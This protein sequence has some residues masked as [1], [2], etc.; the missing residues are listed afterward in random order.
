MA[1]IVRQYHYFSIPENQVHLAVTIK[2]H[3]VISNSLPRGVIYYGN[4]GYGRNYIEKTATFLYTYK[5]SGNTATET[6]AWANPPAGDYA[7]IILTYADMGVSEYTINV[8]TILD[9]VYIEHDPS[10]NPDF[11]DVYEDGQLLNDDEYEFQDRHLILKTSGKWIHCQTYTYNDQLLHNIAKYLSDK[12]NPSDISILVVERRAHD[13]EVLSCDRLRQLGYNVTIDESVNY[14]WQTEGYDIVMADT[15]WWGVAKGSLLSDVYDARRSVWSTGDNSGGY[16]DLGDIQE[17]S[18]EPILAVSFEHYDTPQDLTTLPDMSWHPAV[19]GIT[20]IKD[21]NPFMHASDMNYITR[22]RPDVITLMTHLNGTPA[23]IE[24]HHYPSTVDVEYYGDGAYRVP[25]Q[26][27]KPGFTTFKDGTQDLPFKAHFECDGVLMVKYRTWG[28][29]ADLNGSQ[30]GGLVFSDSFEYNGSSGSSITYSGRYATSPLQGITNFTVLVPYGYLLGNQDGFSTEIMHMGVDI[31]APLNTP[32]RAIAGGVVSSAGN[33]LGRGNYVEILHDGYIVSSYYYLNSISVTEGDTVEAGQII[34]YSRGMAQEISVPDDNSSKPYLH[35]ELRLNGEDS[36][37]VD[38]M[39]YLLGQ[40]PLFIQEVPETNEVSVD[41]TGTGFVGNSQLVIAHPKKY[42]DVYAMDYEL[43]INHNA[44]FIYDIDIEA[45]QLFDPKYS[46]G[47]SEPVYPN[48]FYNE[49]FQP[50]WRTKNMYTNRGFQHYLNGNWGGL[51]ARNSTNPVGSTLTLEMTTKYRYPGLIDFVCANTVDGNEFRFYVDGHLRYILNKP[52]DFHKVE[53]FVD[54]G[55]H[56]F[57]WEYKVNHHG[58][59][60]KLDDIMFYIDKIYCTELKQTSYDYNG[61]SLV[62]IYIDDLAVKSFIGRGHY[63]G[64]IPVSKDTK[65]IS[66]E[67]TQLGG[68]YKDAV[69]INKAELYI[70]TQATLSD[71]LEYPFMGYAQILLDGMNVLTLDDDTHGEWVWAKTTIPITPGD[72]DI[73]VLYHIV[74]GHMDI[75]QILVWPTTCYPVYGWQCQGECL[76]DVIDDI[77]RRYKDLPRD[78]VPGGQ[79]DIT[80]DDPALVGAIKL[81]WLFT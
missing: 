39:P 76:T 22:L 65:R 21:T 3:N 80:P 68:G 49:N 18:L 5:N 2:Y 53:F 7:I 46:S 60:L 34:G 23:V 27:P 69:I 28:W 32:V 19:A 16:V 67:I 43:N 12:D 63:S 14:L 13:G 73:S 74:S 33:K 55:S 79:D 54:T 72:Y 52:K 42:D 78:G 50:T 48:V 38:P 71:T 77:L 66:I 25:Y 56:H 35:F 81:L 15:S 44:T 41:R 24:Y 17:S 20:S 30:Y 9:D 6:F 10:N 70:D 37:A 75:G 58:E 51:A 61:N 26:P 1:E 57:K 36:M 45:S 59:N 47:T 64:S 62:K 31:S 29:G 40:Q 11:V 8:D 4:T